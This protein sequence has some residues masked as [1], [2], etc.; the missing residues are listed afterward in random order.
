LQG[1]HNGLLD[2]GSDSFSFI[3]KGLCENCVMLKADY[4]IASKEGNRLELTNGVYLHHA[5]I[6]NTSQKQPGMILN[7][8]CSTK[9]NG[10]AMA[11]SSI[12]KQAGSSNMGMGMGMSG[13]G[14]SS[15]DTKLDPQGKM[16]KRQIGLPDSSVKEMPSTMVTKGHEDL[17]S[18]YASPNSTLK[19]GFWLGMDD[20]IT[21]SIEAINY[22]NET[23]DVYFA[24]DYEYL[25]FPEGKPQKYFDVTLGMLSSNGCGNI[26]FCQ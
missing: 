25:L 9:N 4:N 11:E 3:F 26:A 19:T 23:K 5:I 1:K 24:V 6:M 22:K 13:H 17:E 21:A 10:S 15:R 8:I 14:H 18:F 12:P 16:Q 2:P 20:N 7:A